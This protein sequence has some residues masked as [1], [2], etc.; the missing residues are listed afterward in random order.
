MLVYIF[1]FNQP[2]LIYELNQEKASYYRL[3]TDIDNFITARFYEY[4]DSVQVEILFV[5]SELLLS[6]LL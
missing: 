5:T 2:I 3:F 1:V 4:G 6:E